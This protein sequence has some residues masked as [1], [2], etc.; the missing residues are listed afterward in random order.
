MTCFFAQVVS[1]IN[2]PLIEMLAR[3]IDYPDDIA[4]MM[5]LGAPLVGQLP[6]TGHGVPRQVENCNIKKLLSER[7]KMNLHVFER[8]KDDSQSSWLLQHSRE[9]VAA[10]RLSACPYADVLSGHMTISP[11]FAVEQGPPRLHDY[12]VM[13]VSLRS[14]LRL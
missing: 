13:S 2:G 7:M 14:G 8:V 1:D 3:A 11:R 9:E 6:T 5:R 4:E 12:H 10:G